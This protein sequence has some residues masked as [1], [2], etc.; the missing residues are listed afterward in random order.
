[1]N[2][3]PTKPLYAPI[4]ARAIGDDNLSSLDLRVLAVIAAHDRLGANGVGCYANHNRLAE[5]VGCHLKS[6]SRSLRNLGEGGYIEVAPHPL[7]RRL[8]VYRVLYNDRDHAIMK[9]S[10]T[11]IGSSPVTNAGNQ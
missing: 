11:A 10:R 6:L 3:R 1:M 9:A 7:N 8:R 5:I 2:T 4:P